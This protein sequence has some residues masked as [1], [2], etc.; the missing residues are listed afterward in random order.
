MVRDFIT[1]TICHQ[2]QQLSYRGDFCK[3]RQGSAMVSHSLLPTYCDYGRRGEE[4]H[5]LA[6]TQC[7][8]PGHLSM[9]MKPGIDKKHTKT[10]TRPPKGEFHINSINLPKRNQPTRSWRGGVRFCL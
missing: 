4:G 5:Q 3:Q 10:E 8:V 9:W 6:L 7:L 1:G 2:E